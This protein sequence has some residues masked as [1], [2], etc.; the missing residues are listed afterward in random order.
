[1]WAGVYVPAWDA[2]STADSG[3]P[4]FAANSSETA[5][6]AIQAQRPRDLAVGEQILEGLRSAQAEGPHPIA[7]APGPNGDG[8]PQSRRVE[9]G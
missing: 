4:G 5:T 8:R 1:M 3:A 7:L 2:L 9:D 6:P